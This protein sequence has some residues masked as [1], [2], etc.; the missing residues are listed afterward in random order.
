MFSQ[1]KLPLLLLLVIAFSL[2]FSVL[3]VDSVKFVYDANGN[4]VESEADA[5]TARFEYDVYN[6][7]VGVINAA[8]AKQVM[9]YD[10]RGNL[11]AFIDKM[12]NR[13]TFSY[14][15]INQL[16]ATQDALGYKTHAV[17][18]AENNLDVLTD[19]LGG[20]LRETHSALSQ[21][22]SITNALGKTT[23]Y[24]YTHDGSLRERVNA[25]GSWIRYHRNDLGW[26]TSI[27]YSDGTSVSIEYDMAGNMARITD[28]D[29]DFRYVYDALSRLV[30]VTD[31]HL[32]KSVSYAYDALGQRTQMV[33][34]AGTVV[35]YKYN[36]E[37]LPTAIIRDGE[38]EIAYEY[39][40]ST[41]HV[42]ET[43]GNGVTHEKTLDANGQLTRS[44]HRAL[45]GN[46]LSEI[47][48]QRDKRG[49]ITQETRELQTP[50]GTSE[51]SNIV[52]AYDALGQLV[53]EERTDAD[54]GVVAYSHHYQYDA[55]GNRT[56]KISNDGVVVRYTYNAAGQLLKE[57]ATRPALEAKSRVF[58]AFATPV[59]FEESRNAD[60]ETKVI[61]YTYDDNG[62]LV[63]EQLGTQV[64]SYEYDVEGRL[65]AVDTPHGRTAY[66]LT[67]DGKRVGIV[68]KGETRRLM[69]DKFDVNL[70][71]GTTQT[72]YLS[73]LGIDQVLLKEEEGQKQYYHR[74]TANSV[75]QLSDATGEIVST[76]D[77]DAF[78]QSVLTQE[79]V[80]NSHTFSARTPEETADTYYFRERLY[81]SRTGRFLSVDPL[82][83]ADAN[84]SFRIGS[85]PASANKE[86]EAP[87]YQQRLTPIGYVYTGQPVPVKPL[88]DTTTIAGSPLY[89]Q[90]LIA[91]TTGLDI[92]GYIY[93]GNN[94]ANHTD[95]TGEYG[96]WNLDSFSITSFCRYSIC[97][98]SACESS[99]C[100]GS[101]CI[102]SGCIGSL[103]VETGCF[104]SWCANGDCG[105]STN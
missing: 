46:V 36:S 97:L 105:S 56:R 76:Y 64:V 53:K 16:I 87:I 10:V 88:S 11:T 50:D 78:G 23:R 81:S 77:Y 8:G 66:V 3:A 49:V 18:D 63:R 1:F 94:P 70:E 41:H 86:A 52:Y 58:N 67:P 74:G 68:K 9:E 55:Q 31:V 28:A 82:R 14:N 104:G 25:D 44:V 92:S 19:A 21:L 103:C 102:Y 35:E 101:G 51:K 48:Y 100:I 80:E 95:P 17:L 12:G 43:L 40:A 2:P 34:A 99:G 6:R 60:T 26:V 27:A 72:S 54:T 20:E 75:F 89:H 98:V 96:W 47:T 32:G 61:N 33:D 65:I 37:G 73:A 7:K 59:S 79:G 57:E 5:E 13:T 15:A 85:L 24:A 90:R 39:D 22:T 62:N 38:V 71:I 4:L 93:V 29:T 91:G 42:K 30:K 45:D 69:H 83:A 84:R